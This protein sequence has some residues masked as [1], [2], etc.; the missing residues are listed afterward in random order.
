MF[1]WNPFAFSMIQQ[2]LAIWSLIPLPFLNSAWTSGS[3]R[4]AC[5]EASLAGLRALQRYASSCTLKAPSVGGLPWSSPP[6]QASSFC[7]ASLLEPLE[8]V[9]RPEVDRGT[10]SQEGGSKARVEINEKKMGTDEMSRQKSISFWYYC[11]DQGR[12]PG[13][14]LDPQPHWH[15]RQRVLNSGGELVEKYRSTLGYSWVSKGFSVTRPPVFANCHP[16][17][18]K[19]DCYPS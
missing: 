1:F 9:L 17:V 14:S 19:I 13:A 16:Q 5:C 6:G 3:S 18:L 2:M 15:K 10:H 8:T 12:M 4:F 7:S 11:Q